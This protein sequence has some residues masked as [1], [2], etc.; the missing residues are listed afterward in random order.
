[1]YKLI[2]A[3]LVALF[4]FATPV[5]AH[6][7]APWDCHLHRGWFTDQYGRIIREDVRAR[8]RHCGRYARQLQYRQRYTP[9]YIRIVPQQQRHRHHGGGFQ[10][11]TPDFKFR[12]GW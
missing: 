1:M 10:V 3:A 9:P 12:M 11:I 7:A 8:V 4:A 6:P 2:L 5:A